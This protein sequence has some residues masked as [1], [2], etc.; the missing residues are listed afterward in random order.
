MKVFAYFNLHRK[1]WSLRGEDGLERGYV[2]AHAHAVELAD[3]TFKVS[4]ASRQKV[5]RDQQ[6]NVH[7]GIV[8]TL[9]GFSGKVSEIGKDRAAYL[10]YS[11]DQ[12][13]IPDITPE[14]EPVTYN[15]Y[16]SGDFRVIKNDAPIA[17]A[18]SVIL[19]GLPFAYGLTYA[20]KSV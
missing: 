13:D 8:G 20:E 14:Y 16:V 19:S 18:D 15:P 2:V 3:C 4:E 7:A 5:I 1:T 10:M 11:G 12:D 9:I 6:K 17:A